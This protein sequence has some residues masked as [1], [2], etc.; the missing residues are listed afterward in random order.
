MADLDMR[1]MMLEATAEVR[2]IFRDVMME[3]TEPQIEQQLRAQWAQMPQE[4]RERFAVERP[5]EYKELMKKI[6]G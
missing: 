2:A 6:G 5:E 4:A 1:D 3:M